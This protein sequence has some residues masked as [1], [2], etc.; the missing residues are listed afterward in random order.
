MKLSSYF[1]L[2][3]AQ[4]ATVHLLFRKLC[5]SWVPKQLIPEHKAKHME[6]AL[7]L[8]QWYYDDG[9]EFQDQIIIGDEMWIAHITP[10]TK[11]QSIH[12]R[13]SGSPCKTE[14]KQTL[15]WEKVMFMMCLGQTGILLVDF[16]IRGE[17][18]NAEHYCRALQKL[19]W[20]IQNK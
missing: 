17:T 8:L 6:S 11:Q 7:T 15:L 4:I 18:V 3:V 10:E 12:W 19:R 16:L 1:P 14:F 5:A 20:S 2:H 13:H 9:D